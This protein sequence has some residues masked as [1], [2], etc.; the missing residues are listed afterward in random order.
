MEK[1]KTKHG[2]TIVASVC[3][4]I[5]IFAGFGFLT[6]ARGVECM[7]HVMFPQYWGSDQSTPNTI[8]VGSGQT[9]TPAG[10]TRVLKNL[11]TGASL[12]GSPSDP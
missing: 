6:A 12:A 10:R 5:S 3:I 9:S 1:L 7:W 11:Q 4:A 8:L 2:L